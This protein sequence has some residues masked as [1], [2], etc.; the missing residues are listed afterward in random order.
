MAGQRQPAQVLAALNA[1]LRQPHLGGGAEG[2]GGDNGGLSPP[3]RRDRQSEAQ[4]D[5]EKA[6]LDDF[7]VLHARRYDFSQPAAA[8]EAFGTTF[9]LLVSER[10]LS[11]QNWGRML[12]GD[13][14]LRVLQCMRVLMRDGNH[15]RAFA[16]TP[17]AV[18]RLC[19]LCVELARDHLASLGANF[20]S[21]MLVE[22]LSI[23]KR[24]A[25]L[26]ELWPRWPESCGAIAAPSYASSAAASLC[27]SASAS[28]TRTPTQSARQSAVPSPVLPGPSFIEATPNASA[29]PSPLFPHN[30]LASEA[31]TLDLSPAF[32]RP[33]PAAPRGPSGLSQGGPT[34]G[35]HDSPLGAR[36]NGPLFATRLHGAL[37]ALLSTR[38]ALVLQCVLV[39]LYQFVQVEHHRA[40]I[41]CLGCAEILLR[42]LS[43]YE[44]SFKVLAA[45]LLELLLRSQP[46]CREVIVHDGA[47]TLLSLL[48]SDDA[49]LPPPLL[50]SLRRLASDPPSAKE[51][52]QLG[53]I[54]VLLSLIV[55]NAAKPMPL[56]LIVGA[57]AVLTALA[58]DHDAALQVRK[59]NGIYILGTQLLALTAAMA[60]GAGGAAAAPQLPLAE[61]LNA[62]TKQL[63]AQAAPPSTEGAGSEAAATAAHVCRALRYVY[64]MERNRKLFRRLFPPDLFAAFIDVGQYVESVAHYV[65]IAAQLAGLSAEAR[66]KIAEALGDVN[67]DKGRGAEQLYVRDYAVQELLGKG[68]FGS[69]YQV[70]GSGESLYAMKELP[71]DEVAEAFEPHGGG[72]KTVSAKLLEREV[73]ILSSL[74]HPNIIR[75]FDSFV[76]KGNLYI[77]MELVDGATL[78]DHINSFGEKGAFLTEERIWH[79]FCQVCMALRYCH[80]AKHVVHRDLTPSNIM[81]SDDL[82]VKLADFGLARQRLGTN[83]V[84]ESVV[85]SV[86]YQCPELIQHEAYGE[87]ADIWALGCILYQ[88]ATLR[89]PF[90]GGN[91]LVVAARIVE[92]IYE[93]VPPGRYSALLVQTVGAMLTSDPARRPDID[94][95]A[96]LVSPVLMAQLDEASQE[97]VALREELRVERDARLKHEREAQHH[98]EAVHRLFARHQLDLAAAGWGTRGSVGVLGRDESPLRAARP[99]RESTRSPMLSVSPNRIREIHDPCSRI[100]HQLHKI[101]FIT[102]LPPTVNVAPE[103][104]V[105]EKYKHALFSRRNHARGWNLKDELNKLLSGSDVA[106]DL[107][108]HVPGLTTSSLSAS[109]SLAADSAAADRPKHRLSYEELQ[110]C[111]EQ[112]LS[113]TGYY[114]LQP[115]EAQA[116]LPAPKTPDGTIP[117]PLDLA[118]LA[119]ASPAF[120][121]QASLPASLTASQLPSPQLTPLGAS[122]SLLHA[123]ASHPLPGAL[124]LPGSAPPRTRPDA[125]YAANASDLRAATAQNNSGGSGALNS[126]P[127]LRRPTQSTQPRGERIEQRPE[128]ERS[129]GH[130]SP[131]PGVGIGRRVA[132]L[133]RTGSSSSSGSEVPRGDSSARVNPGLD[134]RL[135]VEPD[136]RHAGGGSDGA[137]AMRKRPAARHSLLPKPGHAPLPPVNHTNH[138]PPSIHIPKQ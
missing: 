129:G 114:A 107:A 137:S 29:L 66:A 89:P 86:L 49:Q 56:A 59:A 54:N 33:R 42:I 28:R 69:V 53:G 92:A 60:E 115:D 90:E 109:H 116:A 11:K 118:L 112:V 102:Q 3:E 18:G 120:A 62:S 126:T 67:T 122:S 36:P 19:G 74:Q 31:P 123:N 72:E 63:F 65:P 50:R 100:L 85:G 57:C 93:P 95:V 52:R 73:G 97:R 5:A 111:I 23:L 80:K 44:P 30:W 34:E 125:A 71:M 10:F 17:G 105:I 61:R 87:K 128:R 96:R 48:H 79:I 51:V 2:G 78:L 32:A 84:M 58:T 26:Q 138:R 124:S 77:L 43:E 113:D 21:E 4:Q 133:A 130:D 41:G 119:D 99:P 82:T 14:R 39:A 110:R 98:K 108:F 37:V 8:A 9:S 121:R 75:Y 45:E 13:F 1:L 68:G 47:S 127:K 94:D 64:S 134:A 132:Q 103:R 104:L 27:G 83:S 46:F 40:A 24:F 81:V 38:E 88:M 91:P 117:P 20:A 76:E 6:A 35:G 16:G 131:H 55:P 106:I 15:R 12:S 7:L 136:P 22:T 135:R 70:K 25:A 101:L